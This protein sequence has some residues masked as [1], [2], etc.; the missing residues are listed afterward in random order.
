[1]LLLHKKKWL[2]K[3]QGYGLL[4]LGILLSVLVVIAMVSLPRL[5]FLQH[6][7]YRTEIEKMMLMCKYLQRLALVHNQDQYLHIFPNE[8]CYEGAGHR[9]YLPR[10]LTFSVLPGVY[11]P[12]SNPQQLL[13]AYTTFKD[14]RIVF[15]AQGIMQ[16]G[17][18]YLADRDNKL[19]YAISSAVSPIAHLRAY[20]YDLIGHEW[21]VL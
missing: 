12:P 19:M 11:G 18:I 1:M 5:S 21:V 10:G 13:Q 14:D 3:Q 16:S 8:S 9:E 20:T 17:T 7:L 15:Y 4:Q 6:Q 2:H